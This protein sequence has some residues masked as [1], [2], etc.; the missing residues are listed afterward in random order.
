M[1]TTKMMVVVAVLVVGMMFGLGGAAQ[2]GLMGPG[3]I[4]C[5]TGPHPTLGRDWAAGDTYHLV[6]CTSTFTQATSTDIAYYNTFVNDVA[7]GSS[8]TGVPDVTWYAV[9]STPTTHARDNALVSAPV[10]RL[11]L[12]L[13]ADGFGD[14]WDGAIAAAINVDENGV[15]GIEMHV[16]SGSTGL[17]YTYGPPTYTARALGDAGPHYGAVHLTDG[18]WNG[19]WFNKPNTESLSLYSLSDPLTITAAV[20]VPE[21]AGLGLIG[22]ALLA[23]RKRRA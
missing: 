22:L 6:F 4:V 17:G 14:L 9:G 21:P 11:D 19:G 16:W 3:G 8:L 5:P 1:K 13:V 20:P 23:I 12:A 10:Y 15:G 18:R 2:A 7:D